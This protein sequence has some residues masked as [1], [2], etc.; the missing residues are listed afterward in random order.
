MTRPDYQHTVVLFSDR[1][2]RRDEIRTAVG[3]RPASDIGRIAWIECSTFAE[4]LEALDAGG[5]DLAVLDGEAQPTGGMGLCRQMKH[6]IDDCPPVCV[7][8]QRHDDRWLA[9]WSM[10]DATLTYPIDPITA[11]ATVAEQLRRR[12]AGEPVVG[13]PAGR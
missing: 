12:L 11:A 6:E 8:I 3:R 2:H 4:V 9:T 13:L 7:V 10:A 5:I 1:P